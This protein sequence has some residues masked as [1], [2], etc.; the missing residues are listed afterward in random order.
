MRQ[1]PAA[2]I[3]TFHADQKRAPHGASNEGAVSSNRQEFIYGTTHVGLRR[4]TPPQQRPG[5]RCFVP[6]C[7]RSPLLGILLSPL[8]ILA[9][10]ERGASEQNA[11]DAAGSL[12]RVEN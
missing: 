2:A 7:Q 6:T 3:T 12:M 9:G 1:M 10:T 4:I 11:A 5:A 8:W